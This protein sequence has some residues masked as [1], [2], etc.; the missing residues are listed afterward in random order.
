MERDKLELVLCQVG[1]NVF[2]EVA[3]DYMI[4]LCKT[5]DYQYLTQDEVW[6]L[7]CQRFAEKENQVCAPM[8]GVH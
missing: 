3:K 8:K 1:D 4:Y 6:H 2:F 5:D 7:V